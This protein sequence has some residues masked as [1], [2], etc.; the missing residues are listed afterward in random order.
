MQINFWKITHVEQAAFR[1]SSKA[2]RDLTHSW[3]EARSK[4]MQKSAR[5]SLETYIPVALWGNQS[6]L[7]LFANASEV[8]QAQSQMATRDE[9]TVVNDLA[10][11]VDYISMLQTGET[12]V[13]VLDN[14]GML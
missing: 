3:L 12:I 8:Q 11:V 14:S 6:D 9:H 4:A 2:I 1:D 5:K 10:A 7:S 13:F